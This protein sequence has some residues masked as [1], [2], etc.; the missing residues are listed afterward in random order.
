[1]KSLLIFL[2]F[3]TLHQVNSFSQ[4]CGVVFPG[5]K[6]QS[7]V[8]FQHSTS[9]SFQS[10]TETS[11]GFDNFRL[12]TDFGEPY[13]ATNPNNPLN[14]ICAF[15]N[16]RV[17][18]TQDGV[19]WNSVIATPV[20]C[21]DP[22]VC[23]DSLGTAYYSYVIG[24]SEGGRIARST[25][26]GLSW[27]NF[28]LFE[29]MDKSSIAAV[30]SGG[31][32]SNYLYTIWQYFLNDSV[33]NINFSRSTNRAENWSAPLRLNIFDKA[34][35][36]WITIGPNGQIPGGNIYCGYNGITENYDSVLIMVRR[37]TDAGVTF[38]NER[39]I[40]SFKYPGVP[41]CY[42]IK[43]CVVEI[44]ACI[45]MSADNSYK[46]SRGNLYVVYTARTSEVDVADIYF[47]KSTDY[48]STWSVPRKLNDDISNTDQW[49]PSLSVDKNTGHLFISWLDSRV[50]PVNNYMAKLFG[51]VST[52]GGT[53]FSPNT[54]ISHTSF[55]PRIIARQY[56][57]YIGHYMGISPI[58]R[59]SYASWADARFNDF[60]SYT[61]YY[62]DFAMLAD[63]TIVNMG[64]NDSTTIVVKIP[65]IN[66]PFNEK[67]TFSAEL[68]TLPLSGNINF[69]FINRDFITNIPDS[70]S[71]KIKTAGVTVPRLHRL[72]IK[73]NA[74]ASIAPVHWRTI[75][76][77]VNS[78]FLNIGTNR[79]RYAQY[80]VNNILYNTN[81]QLPF[82]NGSKVT[83]QALTPFNLD[84]NTRYIF[85]NWSDSGDTTHVI[86][87]SNNY[88]LT[89][90]FKT[91]FRFFLTSVVPNTFGGTN[92]Y[93]S[94]QSHT[95]GVLSRLVNYNG[96]QYRF[97]GWNGAGNGSYTSP[98]S[99]GIDTLVT[100]NINNFIAEI[101]RWE[102]VI[103]I[104]SLNSEIPKEF[105][106][107]QNHPN[108]FNP[109]TEIKIDIP[110]E[111]M[112]KITIYDV[113][114]R[115]VETLINSKLNPGVY[116]INW[117]GSKYA[118]GIYFYT[119]NSDNFYDVKRLVLLK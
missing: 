9:S 86:Q 67:I 84:L 104:I 113:L 73:A 52:D 110:I 100:I 38:L 79:N 74:S 33:S 15:N 13:I 85:S 83:V 2:S 44:N 46:S 82:I 12:G 117:D 116:L 18:I 61:A 101:A 39:V 102:P 53:T 41:G 108:P 14:S 77:L 3:L 7:I 16:N 103:G 78:S 98:D 72:F 20:L 95:F 42:A 57:G 109:N 31:P 35:C 87:I 75:N 4:C 62:P 93:D 25:N 92:F 119:L 107:Y 29:R 114:G 55:D 8:R 58:N 26:Q 105:K 1:M 36:A 91:Q 27:T 60:G 111:S 59:S 118:S 19:N 65:A 28:T 17:Y 88:N 76:L 54:Q 56:N 24:I 6:N 40:T 51:T 80:K 45:Q 64:S 81:Q 112:T 97:R 94:S 48:G 70:V 66:G 71:I 11:N 21:F 10:I 68:D 96:Q 50:D 49:L 106:L 5:K 47:L 22:F 43:D 63:P 30:Q 99:S 23:F 34:Y 69:S 89:A 37:S 90:F 115:E 32:Y